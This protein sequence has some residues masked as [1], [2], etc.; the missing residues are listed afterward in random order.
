MVSPFS[1]H[2]QQ[3]AMLAQHQSFVM[4]AAAKSAGSDPK[5]AGITQQPTTN[6]INVSIQS[7]P[8]AGYQIPGMMMPAGAQADVQK[9][10]Q[11]DCT[12]W[13]LFLMLFHFFF[14]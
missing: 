12:M 14:T 9:L 6:G 4:A 13:L 11:V 3:L 5:F 7:W 8:N 10:T 1:I 2:Q